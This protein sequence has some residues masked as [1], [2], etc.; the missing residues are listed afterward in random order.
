MADHF[1]VV[2]SLRYAIIS[3]LRELERTRRRKLLDGKAGERDVCQS[4]CAAGS[5][6][7][8]GSLPYSIVGSRVS[9]EAEQ[10]QIERTPARRVGNL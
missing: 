9:Y 8:A 1:K 3:I 5:E 7:V 2:A 10:G 6:R 4:V